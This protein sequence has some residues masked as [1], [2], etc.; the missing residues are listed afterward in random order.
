VSEKVAASVRREAE[1]HA[2]LAIQLGQ[3]QDAQADAA[4]E[5]QR[6]AD[7]AQRQMEQRAK[8]LHRT[9]STTIEGILTDIDQHR[10]PFVAIFDNLKRGAIRAI[11][12][13]LATKIEG[14]VG[15]WL[16]IQMPATKQVTAAKDMNTAADKML[17]AA[18]A[19]N[20]GPSQI[21]GI[22]ISGQGTSGAMQR[23]LQQFAKIGGAAYGGF[24][25]GYGI[26]SATESG[27]LGAVGG[28]FAGAKLGGAIAGPYGAAAGAIAGFVGGIIGAGD[29]ARAARERLRELKEAFQLTFDSLKAE[30]N[31][32]TLAQSIAQVTAQYDAATKQFKEA[33]SIIS[34]VLSGGKKGLEDYAATLKQL[35]EMEKE[36]IAQLKEEAATIVR[37]AQEDLDVRTLR[38][39]GRQHDADILNKQHEDERELAKAISEHMSDAYIAQLKQN[40]AMEEAAVAAGL[41]AGAIN[42]FTTAVRGSPSGFKLAGYIQEFG[43]G[44]PR[45]GSQPINPLPLP[46][47]PFVPPMSPLSPPTLSRTGT[48]AGMSINVNNPTFTFPNAKDGPAVAKAFLSELDRYASADGGLN[49][50]R[51]RALEKMP[52]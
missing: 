13:I 2:R 41:A 21:A 11:S 7:E 32:D 40:Q 28:A 29:A 30:L 35:G 8:E 45:P 33:N 10:N 26:G 36:R 50:S 14:K 19:M 9:I 49:G 47:N 51:T 42:G 44:L 31:H 38:N 25:T 5:A 6:A 37:N 46:I 12:D 20:G 16:G 52:S 48:T 15:E 17:R 39:Q 23:Y 34:V 27:T 4:R 18:G 24:Q 43:H 3:V 1:E 22:T